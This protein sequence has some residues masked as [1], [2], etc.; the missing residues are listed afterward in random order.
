MRFFIAL[1]FF[2]T[3]PLQ[4]AEI[5]ATVLYYRVSEPGID[6]YLSRWLIT[7][8]FVRID[9]GETADNYILL[10]RSKRMVY[11]VVHQDRTIL[12]IPNRTVSRKPDRSLK[13]ESRIIR[14][15]KLPLVDGKKPLYRELH[16]NDTLCH[17]VVSVD[18]LLP[19]AVKAMGEYH[20]VMA[21]EH[22]KNMGNTPVEMRQP[23]DL[24]LLVFNPQWPAEKGLPIREW[25]THG[26]AL[27][28]LDYKTGEVVDSALFKFPAGYRHYESGAVQ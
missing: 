2:M 14:D 12:D 9:E 19:D 16:V 25:D 21:G 3:L 23:C 7:D 10:D 24:V 5:K 26:K 13:Q 20:Q 1:L 18:T 28:L 27:E 6:P 11:S 4:A 8:K 22:A 15:D 17:S